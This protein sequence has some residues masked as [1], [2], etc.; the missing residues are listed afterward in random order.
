[1]IN[2]EQ[3]FPSLAH[4]PLGGEKIVGRGLIAELGV[5]GDVAKAINRASVLLCTA[6]NQTATFS[7]GH[8]ASM[9]NHCIEMFAK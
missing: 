3:F 8:F 9:S 4:L 7:R 1:M 6:A 2:R 5:G